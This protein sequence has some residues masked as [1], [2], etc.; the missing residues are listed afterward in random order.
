V[1]KLQDK[2]HQVRQ[3]I[4]TYLSKEVLSRLRTHKDYSATTSPSNN[5]RLMELTKETIMKTS[6]NPAMQI[7][8]D[9]PALRQTKDGITTTTTSVH[10]S[11]PRL[12]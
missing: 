6:F 9:W 10:G 3:L 5:I 11:I 4:I 8:A 2:R 1:E 7:K 12:S